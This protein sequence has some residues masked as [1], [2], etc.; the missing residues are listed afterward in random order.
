MAR[1]EVNRLV[2]SRLVGHAAEF[3]DA[4]DFWLL[5]WANFQAREFPYDEARKLGMSTLDVDDAVQAGLVK[6]KAGQG[7]TG[8]AGQPRTI[9]AIED[10]GQRTLPHLGR[11]TP[12][13]VN[14]YR[15][16]G[17]ASTRT[18]LADSGYG[19]ERAFLDTLQA[20]VNAIPRVRTKKGL[21]VPEAQELEDVVIALFGDKIEI[22]AEV[23]E[24]IEAQQTSLEV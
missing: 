8:Q 4:T 7:R 12:S 20:S 3:D 13:S 10:G 16:D 22:P 17:L 9:T 18:W 23:E 5:C 14:S 11:C 24:L 21:S 2:K 6:K 1:E 19:D 15:D